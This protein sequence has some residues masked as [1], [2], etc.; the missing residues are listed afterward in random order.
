MSAVRTAI[1][2]VLRID[3]CADKLVAGTARPITR[4]TTLAFGQVAV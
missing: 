3:R 4:L 1:N 2:Q